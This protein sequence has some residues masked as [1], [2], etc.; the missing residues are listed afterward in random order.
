MDRQ[1]VGWMVK[2]RDGWTVRQTVWWT[3]RWIFC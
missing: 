1:M 3:G 2:W